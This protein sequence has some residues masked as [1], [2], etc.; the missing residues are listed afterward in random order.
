MPE[1][2]FVI[3]LDISLTSPGI[4]VFDNSTNEYTLYY[5]RQR[6][7]D[8]VQVQWDGI[9]NEK[10]V[11]LRFL[12][13]RQYSRQREERKRHTI[14]TP[15]WAVYNDKSNIICQVLGQYPS[16]ESELY[17]EGYSFMSQG[18]SAPTK[19]YEFGGVLRTKLY[20]LGYSIIEVPPTR[21]KSLFTG[22][23]RSK[24]R[25]MYNKW[26]SLGLPN[27]YDLFSFPKVPKHV[28]KPI[29]DIVDAFALCTICNH[30]T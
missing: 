8:P 16:A 15:R 23:G 2:R 11:V 7:R 28:P 14:E 19:L 26:I 4:C 20:E 24:K 1:K 3:G 27:L 12:E 22:S 10:H 21:I 13:M 25:D 9:Y 17:I 29:E 18:G 6:R 30:C 5:S